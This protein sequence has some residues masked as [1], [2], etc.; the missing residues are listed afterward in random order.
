MIIFK[1]LTQIKLGDF[2][3]AKALDSSEYAST[4][5]GTPMYLSPEICSEKPYNEKTDVWSLACVV[6]ELCTLE[7]A[8]QEKGR[9]FLVSG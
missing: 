8:F 1:N 9:N 2:C 5:I 6:Y 3:I 4:I 7:P